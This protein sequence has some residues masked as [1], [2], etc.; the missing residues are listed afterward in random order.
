[1]LLTVKSAAQR[2]AISQS[3]LYELCASGSLPHVRIARPGSRGIIRIEAAD[4]DGF[5]ARQKTTGKPQ[6]RLPTTKQ[7]FKHVILK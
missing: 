3:L 1:M 7:P 4:L 2:L 6:P 5:I